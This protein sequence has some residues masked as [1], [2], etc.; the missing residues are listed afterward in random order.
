MSER[1][2]C[3]QEHRNSSS[4]FCNHC[5]FKDGQAF[6][7]YQL[8]LSLAVNLAIIPATETGKTEV[9]K[10]DGTHPRSNSKSTAQPEKESRRS[11]SGSYLQTTTAALVYLVCCL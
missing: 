2:L 4:P 3:L 10:W 6:H 8:Y 7:Q 1:L 5:L 9:Q 11:G